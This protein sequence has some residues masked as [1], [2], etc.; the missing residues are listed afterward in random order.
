[1]EPAGTASREWCLQ[2]C[3]SLGFEPDV[4]FTTDDLTSHLRLI[5]AGLAVGL[6]PQLL[7][8]DQDT[9]GTALLPLPDAPA[10]TI[11]TTA[12]R[13]SAETPAAQACRAAIREAFLKASPQ[14]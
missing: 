13:A 6:L 7:L 3:R 1:M 8:T 14:T 10:R 12:R 9:A 11:Y 5:R 2:Q 4:R